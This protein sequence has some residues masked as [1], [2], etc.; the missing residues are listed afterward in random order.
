L[1]VVARGTKDAAS[2]RNGGRGGSTGNGLVNSLSMTAVPTSLRTVSPFFSHAIPCLILAVV[3]TVLFW[4]NPFGKPPQW[5]TFHVLMLSDTSGEAQLM[6]GGDNTDIH[7]GATVSQPVVGG[8]QLNH[9]QFRIPTGRLYGFVFKGLDRTGE[10]EIQKSW[11][12]NASGEVAAIMAPASMQ[13]SIKD[14]RPGSV[15]GSLRYKTKTGDVLAGLSFTLKPPLD[16]TLELPPPVWQIA[17]VFLATLFVGILLSSYLVRRREAIGR[18]LGRIRDWCE[19]RPRRAILLAAVFS[20]AVCAFPVIFGG[21]SY[22]SPNNGMHLLYDHFPTV[23]NSPGGSVENP[24]DS[25]IG[26]MMYWH[27]P[28]SV[29]EHRAIFRD[30]EFPL[31]SRYPYCG[32]T[33]FGQLFT[34]IG[35]PLHWPTILTGGAAWSWDCKFVVAK[36]LFALGIGWLVWRMAGSLPVALVC[37]LSAPYIGFFVYRFCHPSNFAMCYGPWLLV[38]WVEGVRAKTLRQVS[39][40]AGLLLFVEWCEMNSGAAKE[41][42]MLVLFL[43]VSGALLVLMSTESWGWR[44]RRVGLFA[45]SN[46]LFVLLTTPLWLVFLD[47]LGKSWTAYDEP[48]ICQ[49]QPGLAIGLFDDI[50]Y[51]SIVDKE[52]LFSQ[53]ANFFV[54]LGLAW[55]LVRIRT[56]VRDRFFLAALLPA[57]PAAAFVFGVVPTWLAAAIPFI[58]NIYHFEDTFSC[59]LFVLLFILAGIGMRECIASRHRSEWVGD[60]VCV[61]VVIGILLAG[62]FGFTQVTQ[63][64]ARGFLPPGES[65]SKSPFF[66]NYVTILIIAVVTF[67]LALRLAFRDRLAGPAWALVAACMFA[68]LHFRNGMYFETR[69]D[70]YTMNPKTRMDLRSIQSPAIDA[71]HAALAAEP[72]RV[73]GLDWTM[74]PGFQAVF[75]LETISGPDVTTNGP[76]MYLAQALGMQRTY[77]WRLFAMSSDY[78]KARRCLDFLN[79]R[80][81]LNDPAKPQ[82]AGTRQLGSYDLNLYESET[83]WPRAF[84]TDV[85]GTYQDMDDMAEQVKHGDGRPF[86]SVLPA[87]RER[88]P[89]AAKDPAQRVVEKG[90]N[91]R[92]TTNTTSFEIDVPSPGMIVLSEADSPGDILAYLDGQRVPCLRTNLVFRGVYVDRP[93]HHV[94]KFAYWPRLLA[95]ALWVAAFGLAGLLASV[96]LWFRAGSV[97]TG[98]LPAKS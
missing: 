50:F 35:D 6:P 42:M 67:P 66:V 34:M 97:N 95:P 49:V 83:A 31:W 10:I 11:I 54:L 91:Y 39:L 69:F 22:V 70:L 17:V 89:L 3:A 73:L 38:P 88:L 79:V 58:K 20:V 46:L 53:S 27:F 32:L 7:S 52:F 21:K 71:V 36:I 18:A 96:L 1:V 77:T 30:G 47:T 37:T 26:A 51:R 56:L 5:A 60:W 14:A 12:T 28:A 61:M 62:Y 72:A 64:L 68:A 2:Q 29:I 65:L 94:V 24:A 16:L 48:K 63:R 93:G 74:T 90:R 41:P 84:F 76:M 33:F 43:N 75:D 15:A 4:W 25:D 87:V 81:L 13:R 55:A 92:L 85:I 80:Y 8:S 40:W 23:P 57:V 82:P 19:A 45:W 86:A 78:E 98:T 59:V 9:I 44:L